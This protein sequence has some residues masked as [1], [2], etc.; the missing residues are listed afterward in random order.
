MTQ[1]RLILSERE[2]H[3]LV[4]A[5]QTWTDILDVA[6]VPHNDVLDSAQVKLIAGVDPLDAACGE[7]RR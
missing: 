1:I 7:G 3:A 4:S 2:A 6:H 5:V